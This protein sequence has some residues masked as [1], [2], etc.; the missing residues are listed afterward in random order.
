[1][2]LPP[3]DSILRALGLDRAAYAKARTIQVPKAL[4]KLLVEVAL[5]HSE[6]NEA[7][8]LRDN[9]DVVDAI[10]KGD[11][12]NALQHY[13]GY[14]YFEGRTGATPTVDERWY[15][16]TY[17]DVAQGIKLGQVR[18]AK[19]HYNAIGGAEGRSPSAAHQRVAEQWKKAF[20]KG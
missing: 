13:I 6:F 11:V 17:P 9:P 18:S 15:L 5:E 19:D 8:Y 12:A 10:R 3:F 2:Y 4:F 1:M 14:G 7:G 16:A 20:V